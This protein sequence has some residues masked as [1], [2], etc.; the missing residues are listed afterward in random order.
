MTKE[1]LEEILSKVWARDWSAD[2]ARDVIWGEPFEGCTQPIE[3]G[4]NPVSH[5]L[6]E[7]KDVAL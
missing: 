5:G 1:R 6:S 2:D 7:A 3:S 4:N